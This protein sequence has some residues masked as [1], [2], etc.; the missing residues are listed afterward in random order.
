MKRFADLLP[1]DR[2]E[3]RGAPETEIHDVAF[4]SRRVG[5]GSLFVALPGSTVDGGAFIADAIVRGASAIVTEGPIEAMGIPAARVRNARRALSSIAARF[6]D[7]PDRQVTLLGLTGTKGKT[8]T[9][10]MVQSILK[11]HFAR[12]FRFGTV[13]YDLSFEQR[14]ARNTTPESLDLMRLIAECRTHNVPSGVMEVSSHA[15]KTSRVEDLS[16]AAAGFTNLSLEH[17]EFHPDMEDYF[18]AKRR[19]FL[20][21]L[22]SDKPSLI[23]IDDDWGRRLA[24]EIHEA[25]RPLFTISNEDGA[26]QFHA[27]D[28]QM[29][30]TGTTFTLCHRESRIPCR[31]QMPGPFNLANALMAA[32]MCHAVGI[33]WPAIAAGLAAVNNVPGRF[34]TIPNNRQ[35]TVL[36]DYAHS[37]ASLENILQAVQPLLG[38]QGRIITVF[39]CGGN[40][41]REKRPIM[42]KLAATLSDIAI[43]TSDNPRNE[44]P[45]TIIDEIFAGITTLA[46]D[47]RGVIHREADRRAAIGRAIHLGQPGD[48]IIVAGKGH[49]TGQT[50]GNQTLPFDDREV[51]REFLT[52]ENVIHV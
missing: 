12:A 18:Q 32:A 43:V 10:Y 51:C 7:H 30:G 1:A 29:S 48:V 52:K 4:D 16:F 39:G 24:R 50:F 3:I 2:L 15:L 27:R 26:A 20:E 19:L 44:S 42:G 21:L 28:V 34:E 13:E 46:H 31:I 17:T 47:E 37:P 38:P 41:S 8:T 6:F 33:D 40:R 25:G 45:E 14:P 35:L 5:R 9:T 22:P 49:E 23:N 11:R 36:V